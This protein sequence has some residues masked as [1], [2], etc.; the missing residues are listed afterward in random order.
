MPEPLRRVARRPAAGPLRRP[1]LLLSILVVIV[2]LAAAVAPSLFTSR[3]PLMTGTASD[4]LIPPGSGHLFGTDQLGRDLFARVVHGTGLTLRAAGLALLVAVLAGT[5]L[6]LVAGFFGGRVDDAV[7]RLVD[8]L[9]AVPG[10]LLSLAVVTTLGFGTMKVAVAVGVAAVASFARVVRVEALRVRSAPYVEAARSFG[11]PR[12]VVLGRHVLPAAVSPVLV[13][14]TLEFGV[15]IL[16]VSSLSFLGFGARPPTPEW[17]SLV[18]AGR[19][20]MVSAWWLTALPGLVIAAVVLS[21]NRI[22]REIG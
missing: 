5:V 11:V 6:G 17:G 21:A 2:A 15:A 18:A 1:G 20:Y 22:A 8:V 9:L 3:D 16:A 7:M 13:L 14:A 12:L 19:N 4:R 10:L